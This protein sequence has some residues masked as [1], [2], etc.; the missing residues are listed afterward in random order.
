MN[1]QIAK[2]AKTTPVHFI[3]IGRFAFDGGPE[4]SAGALL[5]LG[6]VSLYM[7]LLA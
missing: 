4:H 6:N 5:N 1:R 7:A 3:R 2:T